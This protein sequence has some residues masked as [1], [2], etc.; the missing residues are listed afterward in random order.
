MVSIVC[1]VSKER[2]L[3]KERKAKENASCLI[4]FGGYLQLEK[5]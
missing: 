4:I 5:A 1:L 3:G 2:K